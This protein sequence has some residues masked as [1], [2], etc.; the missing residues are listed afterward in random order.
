MKIQEILD[1][2]NTLTSPYPSRGNEVPSKRV[3]KPL[4]IDSCDVAVTSA[5]ESGKSCP[6]LSPLILNMH[7]LQI[8]F[9]RLSSWA[10]DQ[11]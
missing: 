6:D 9:Q 8:L 11:S 10:F 3:P 2:L 4:P 5:S 7:C 1:T